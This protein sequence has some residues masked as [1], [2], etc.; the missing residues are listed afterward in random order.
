[1]SEHMQDPFENA[2]NQESKLNMEDFQDA[3]QLA[4]K[5]Q[6]FVNY[7][8][9]GI[10]I[11]ILMYAIIIPMTIS[12]VSSM[13]YSDPY[14]QPEMPNI[15]LMYLLIF[16]LW[17]GYYAI[18]EKL[19]G[20]TIGKMASS[21]RVVREDGGP[22]SWGQAIG[23]SAARLIPFEAFS[24]LFSN[25]GVGWHDSLPGTRVIKNN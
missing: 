21:T 3:Y 15:G 24:V 11:S 23:R 7:L 17:I 19:L 22:I 2:E 13:D 25:K 4:S 18:M 1:M 20:K 5:G 9:D 8:I 6:R 16:G 14:A 12:S 10:I